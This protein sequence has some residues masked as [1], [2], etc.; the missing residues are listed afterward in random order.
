MFASLQAGAVGIKAPFEEAVALARKAGFE[1]AALPADLLV[2]RGVEAVREVFEQRGLKGSHWGCPANINAEDDDF[3][4]GLEKLEQVAPLAQQFG[5][6]RCATWMKSWSDEHPYAENFDR[7][8]GRIRRV[9]EILARHNLR[10]GV[11]YLGPETLRQGHKHSFVNTLE[12]M[13]SLLQSAGGDNLG[14]L[15]DAW[16]WH[17][18]GDSAAQ[19]EALKPEQVVL[20]HVND[21]PKGVPTDELI[22]SQRELPGATG[23]ID[24]EAFMGAL[25]RI[26]YDGPVVAEPFNKAVNEME[27]E[28]AAKAVIESI[29]KILGQ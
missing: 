25:R 11:E 17:C 10:F 14:L 6:D 27:D 2:E 7:M 4:R 15:L 9:G 1:G 13:L 23:V 29:R 19:I 16:H 12:E 28:A 8:A 3:E 22:D 18:A 21:A 24:A 26:G 5:C 20:V